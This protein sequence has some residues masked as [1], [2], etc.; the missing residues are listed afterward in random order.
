MHQHL[1]VVRLLDEVVQHLLGVLE[2]GDDA[3]LHGL[4]GD[5]VARRAAEHLLGL[6]ADG[7]HLAGD[8]F[9]ATI[10]GSL[11]MMPL[12]WAKTSVL[13]VPRSMARSD[14]K[15]LNRERMLCTRE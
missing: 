2:V 5:D 10:D 4:D 11:T 12:P 3:V 14:E 7:F 9:T 6:L 1:A 15:R 8:L 13:A